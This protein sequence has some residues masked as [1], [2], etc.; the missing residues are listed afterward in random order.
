MRGSER[1]WPMSAIEQPADLNFKPSAAGGTHRLN[2]VVRGGGNSSF[3][4][5]SSSFSA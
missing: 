2:G 1:A 5:C 4:R 3:S